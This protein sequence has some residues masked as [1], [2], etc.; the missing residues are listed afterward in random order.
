MAAQ[1]TFSSVPQTLNPALPSQGRSIL[2]VCGT[3]FFFPALFFLPQF[4]I[5]CPAAFS[6]R[7]RCGAL[8]QT[9]LST[10]PFWHPC[11]TVNSLDWTWTTVREKR[12][13]SFFFFLSCYN[14]VTAKLVSESAAAPCFLCID[15]FWH[16]TPLRPAGFLVLKRKVAHLQPRPRTFFF[17]SPLYFL[18][19]LFCCF[20]LASS[21]KTPPTSVHSWAR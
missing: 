3:C 19:C 10:K 5:S 12:V 9:T 17:F 15:L 20:L 18:R 7:G 16:L 8:H 13:H 14:N 4:A 11:L 6:R 21:N 2:S 1:K